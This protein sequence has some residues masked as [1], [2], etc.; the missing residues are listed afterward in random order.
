MRVSSRL[1]QIWYIAWMASFQQRGEKWRAVVRRKGHPTQTETF[2][3]K[4]DAQRWA[5]KIEGAIDQGEFSAPSKVPLA[6]LLTRYRNEVTPHKAG[7]KWE[8]TRI[9]KML[10]LPW[11]NM[12]VSDVTDAMGHWVETQRAVVSSA[13][14]NRELNVLSGVF[15]YVIKRWKVGLRSNPVRT[16]VRPARTKARTRRVLP[17][18]LQKLWGH[19]GAAPPTTSRSYVPWAFEFAIET[20]LRTGELIKLRWEDVNLEEGWVYV[21]PSKN[22]DSRHALLT[23][24]AG[25]ILQALPRTAETVF[26][27]NAGTL[28]VMF[29]GGCKDLSIINLHFHDAR[30]EA[31]SRLAKKLSVME[32]AA[33][34]GHRDLKSLLVYYNP[35]PAELA[36]KL[37]GA[38]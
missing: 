16:I 11:V 20:G 9:N 34:I 2:E 15:T 25:E 29:R 10:K 1:V 36:A 6:D 19:F 8:T 38:G 37:R 18:E 14:I 4:A 7:H 32:L 3:R 27:I 12:P 35:T 23:V 31:T 30:H 17:A 28:G 22:G 24:R 21:R 13:T 33:V 5:R 26:P